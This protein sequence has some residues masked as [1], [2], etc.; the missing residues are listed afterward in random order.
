MI[1][2]QQRLTK[3]S[4]IAAIGFILSLF[5]AHNSVAGE[6]FFYPK[7]GQF[8]LGLNFSQTSDSYNLTNDP[9]TSTSTTKKKY[10]S[11]TE[12]TISGTYGITEH[13][14]I[15]LVLPFAT[16]NIVGTQVAGVTG[17]GTAY[18]TTLTGSKNNEI[19]YRYQ[20]KSFHLGLEY[21]ISLDDK[22]YYNNPPASSPVI[23]E[24]NINTGGNEIHLKLG[25]EKAI[26]NSSFGTELRI[27]SKGKRNITKSYS[28]AQKEQRD[29]VTDSN[30]N[31]FYEHTNKNIVQG[32]SYQY[33][34][35]NKVTS[36]G[37]TYS[38]KSI[39]QSLSFYGRFDASESLAFNAKLSF[40]KSHT[41]STTV[42]TSEPIYEIA[43]IGVQFLF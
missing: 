25:Y 1:K 24:E 29:A 10:V 42:T 33:K 4:Y 19:K 9:G 37:V 23:S 18:I 31:L 11:H 28:P 7:E 5:T 15:A 16:T 36:S 3:N 35:N 39:V 40:L 30:L 26:N 38:E 13:Q 8:I 34:I 6:Y 12:K 14:S 27:I 21:H 2:K 20:I 43:D 17:N 41:D 32:V 22:I